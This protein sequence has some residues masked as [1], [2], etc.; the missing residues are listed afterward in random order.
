VNLADNDATAHA[1]ANGSGIDL[2]GG[3]HEA[4]GAEVPCS[5]GRAVHLAK[6]G[7][8]IGGAAGGGT[9]HGRHEGH[10]AIGSGVE[11]LGVLV[12][13]EVLHLHGGATDAAIGIHGKGNLPVGQVEV[14]AGSDRRIQSHVICPKINRASLRGL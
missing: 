5:V 3:A 7:T 1:V 8:G 6:L 9:V 10:G 12:G 4:A 14:A 13:G 11:V 2:K